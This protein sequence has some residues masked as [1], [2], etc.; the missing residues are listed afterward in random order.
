MSINIKRMIP[1]IAAA[2]IIVAAA[3]TVIAVASTNEQSE[4]V[5]FSARIREFKAEKGETAIPIQDVIAEVKSICASGRAVNVSLTPENA[6]A[7]R[8]AQNS[9]KAEYAEFVHKGSC[10]LDFSK[11]S[12]DESDVYFLLLV[13][14]GEFR[15]RIYNLDAEYDPFR[16]NSMP[17][18]TMAYSE[19]PFEQ[20]GYESPKD[21]FSALRSGEC[22]SGYCT[23]SY[24]G[25]NIYGP[26]D[27]ELGRTPE[28]LF[29]KLA[30]VND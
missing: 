6:F 12:Y 5:D 25:A 21:A 22:K 8:Y 29:P 28:N 20:L 3:V 16:S 19:V 24:A 23:V 27:P 4:P 18:H 2:I 30:G 10:A 1:F 13:A 17:T 9:D 15:E 26:F 11:K 14:L 7:V